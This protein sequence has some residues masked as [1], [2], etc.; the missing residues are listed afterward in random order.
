MK[1]IRFCLAVFLVAFLANCQS[2]RVIQSDGN[3]ATIRG[4]K[5]RTEAEAKMAALDGARDHFQG[6]EIVETQE[7]ACEEEMR[8]SGTTTGSS[9]RIRLKTYYRCTV[10]VKKK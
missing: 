6:A 9:T 8:G 10:Y 2:Y 7:A 1:K 3:S 4:H 5:K